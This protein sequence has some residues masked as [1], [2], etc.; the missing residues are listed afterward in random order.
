MSC[1]QGVANIPMGRMAGPKRS[2]IVFLASDKAS[3]ITGGTVTMDGG[4]YPFI[5]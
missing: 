5:L 2:P 3:Y 4:Q 1:R